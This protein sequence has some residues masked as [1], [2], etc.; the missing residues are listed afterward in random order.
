MEPQ[1]AIAE[2]DHGHAGR[3]RQAG[4]LEAAFHVPEI[5]GDLIEHAAIVK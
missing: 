5:G 1:P 4:G 3:N 2:T